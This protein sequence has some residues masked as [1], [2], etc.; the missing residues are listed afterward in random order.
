M[1][2]MALEKKNNKFV[3]KKGEGPPDVFEDN[4]S[5]RLSNVD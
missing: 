4:Y 1:L 5:E 2:K 3:L